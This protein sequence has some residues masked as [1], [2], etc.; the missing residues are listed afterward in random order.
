[1]FGR[2]KR[3][4]TYISPRSKNYKTCPSCGQVYD[5]YPAISRADNKTEICSPC[6]TREA[7]DDFV[8]MSDY[9]KAAK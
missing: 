9:R 3:R 2:Q 6:G 4:S 8:G 5:G 1:M 7:L